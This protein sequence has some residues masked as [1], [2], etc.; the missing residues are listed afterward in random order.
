MKRKICSLIFILFAIFSA[1]IKASASDDTAGS[2]SDAD[3][4]LLTEKFKI[5]FSKE[6]SAEKGTIGYYNISDEGCIAVCFSDDKIAVYD[7]NADF[8]YEYSFNIDG[9][10]TVLWKDSNIVLT[11]SRA[12]LAIELDSDG[13]VADI[14]K[15]DTNEEYWFSI[16]GKIPTHNGYIY[17]KK[18]KQGFFECEL[19]S[20][21][22][23]KSLR[24]GSETIMIE[25]K[26]EALPPFVY[27]VCFPI[28]VLLM[29]FV[30]I[31]SVCANEKHQSYAYIRRKF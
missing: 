15:I 12:A 7:E 17:N 24:D 20:S 4:Q 28:G 11:I 9:V 22:V 16:T 5:S 23:K 25:S 8:M 27:T 10:F 31:Y 30:I 21:I 26:S 3:K 6:E 29:L 19:T 13:N 2:I 18:I 14:T 1:N